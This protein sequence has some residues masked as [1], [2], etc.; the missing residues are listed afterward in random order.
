MSLPS[1]S[2]GSPAGTCAAFVRANTAVATPPLV[3]EL[4]LHLATEVTPLWQA[5]EETLQ[6]SNLPPPYWAFAWPGGQAVARHIFDHPELVRGRRVVDFAA[7][8][9]LVAI[10]AR[11]AGASH[12]LALEI[13]A[14]ALAA[15]ALNADLNGVTVDATVEDL[16]GR[17]LAD[18]DVVLAGDVC[19]EKPMADRVLP[20]L[21]GLAAAGV[22]VLLGDPGRAYR[23]DRGLE[24]VARYAVPTSLELEDRTVRETDVWRL[25]P[26]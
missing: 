26:A 18:A 1:P 7:G 25:L 15:I 16:V 23:P 8:T 19:Y 22:T 9:G 2:D 4:R 10:A 21:R 6:T 14:F 3:P 17:P 13:D 12:A 11:L 5:T 20:W 24:R